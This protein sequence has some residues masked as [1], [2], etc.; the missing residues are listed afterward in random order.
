MVTIINS[1][2]FEKQ[3]EIVIHA[4]LILVYWILADLCNKEETVS[5]YPSH[6]AHIMYDAVFRISMPE[7]F[8]LPFKLDIQ[9]DS[10]EL[11][12]FARDQCAR[13]RP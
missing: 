2:F 4:C 9:R 1:H 13:L 11:N 10:G 3:A 7:D 6:R 8:E 12:T 5:Q